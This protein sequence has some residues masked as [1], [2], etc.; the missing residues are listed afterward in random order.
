MSRE[1]VRT[2]NFAIDAAKFILDLAHRA[3]AERG[4]FRIALSGGN[5]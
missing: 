2:K 3:L 5:T 1:I 4:E